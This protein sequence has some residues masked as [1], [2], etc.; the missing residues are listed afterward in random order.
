MCKNKEIS[1][2]KNYETTWKWNW[3]GVCERIVLKTK[4]GSLHALYMSYTYSCKAVVSHSR[5][6]RILWLLKENWL[7]RKWFHDV[8]GLINS[9]GIPVIPLFSPFEAAIESPVSAIQ[10]WFITW[11]ATDISKKMENDEYPFGLFIRD[12]NVTEK[13]TIQRKQKEQ[14]LLSN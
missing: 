14:Y 7:G 10:Q 4:I 12:K 2:K 9:H 5:G 3:Y 1:L 8:L 11:I 6:H 13:R